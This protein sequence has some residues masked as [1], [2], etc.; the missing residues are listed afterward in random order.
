MQTFTDNDDID[1]PGSSSVWHMNIMNVN[2][3]KVDTGTDM[4]RDM[5]ADTRDRH[6][7][8]RFLECTYVNKVTHLVDTL[9][10]ISS[11]MLNIDFSQFISMSGNMPIFKIMYL[12]ATS[13][14]IKY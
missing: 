6:G 7:H 9:N 3:N 12:P 11:S 14:L 1:L 5:D 10:T 4:D 2:M 13:M 8:Q